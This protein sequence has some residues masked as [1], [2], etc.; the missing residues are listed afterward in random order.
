MFVRLVFWQSL[1]V[2][3]P[4]GKV[5]SEHSDDTLEW[6]SHVPWIGWIVQADENV[7]RHSKKLHKHTGFKPDCVLKTS[8]EATRFYRTLCILTGT[9][10][11][12]IKKTVG[13]R[14]KNDFHHIHLDKYDKKN[15]LKYYIHPKAW[16]CSQ[17]H[18]MKWSLEQT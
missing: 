3:C 12:L 7:S 18:D 2:R 11:C 6:L 9:S 17:R 14:I 10:Y 8:K 13:Y 16:T 5:T 15:C 1:C 4:R